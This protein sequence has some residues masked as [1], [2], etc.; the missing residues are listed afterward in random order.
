MASQYTLGDHNFASTNGPSFGPHQE[1]ITGQEGHASEVPS[2]MPWG[3]DAPKE[4]E[5]YLQYGASDPPEFPPAVGHEVLGADP[6]FTYASVADLLDSAKVTWKWYK[7]PKTLNGHNED[8]YWLDAFDAI[9]AVRYG[10]D[11]ANVVTPDWQ[12][13]NDVANGNLADVTWVM[14]HGGASDHAGGGSG[15]CGPAWVTEVVNAVGQSQYWKS[16][17]IIVT[18][19]EWGGWFDHIL[20]PQYP[21]PETKAYEG[22]GYRVPLIVISP[23]AKTHYVSKSQHETASALHFIEKMF[24]LAVPRKGLAA[25]LRRSARRRVRRRLPVFAETD[26]LQT[27]SCAAQLSDVPCRAAKRA[28]RDGLLT[29]EG[30]EPCAH[31][32]WARASNASV[33]ADHAMRGD[34]E[35]DRRVAHRRSDAAMCQGAAGASGHVGIRDEL[36]EREIRNQRPYGLLKRGTE[37]SERQVEAPQAAGEIRANLLGRGGKQR[38]GGFLDGTPAVTHERARNDRFIR[39]FDD[40]IMTPVSRNPQTPR[41]TRNVHPAFIDKQTPRSQRGPWRFS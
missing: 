5:W 1:L 2:K 20:P 14:P 16:T 37:R 23:Y 35:R 40:Q 8:S 18:W 26:D 6:C 10:P 24:G 15:A 28:G 22:L 7:Q 25:H 33:A 3:C 11:Y 21:N 34:E 13:V 41:G 4:E 30:G 29:L 36:S 19:D 39:G 32:E 12:V 27:D 31:R 9:K 38:A 17:A